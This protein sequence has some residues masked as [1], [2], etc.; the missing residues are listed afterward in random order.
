MEA[1]QLR[2][3]ERLQK[4]LATYNIVACRLM[5][6]TY[7]ARL[8]P[9]ALYC[10]IFSASEWRVLRRKFEPKNR[11]PKTLTLRQSL[12]WVAWLEGFLGRKGDKYPGLKTLWRGMSV[13]HS[14]LE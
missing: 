11:S 5:T 12:I 2:I 8:S 6:L 3:G 10:I 9:E 14:L 13:F 1:L 4:A 7:G